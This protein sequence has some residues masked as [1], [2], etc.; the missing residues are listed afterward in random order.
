MAYDI[1]NL[2]QK[3]YIGADNSFGQHVFEFDV[4]KWLARWP[5]ATFAV[6]INR[7]YESRQQAYPVGGAERTGNILRWTV[8]AA[9]TQKIGDGFAEI[10]AVVGSTVFAKSTRMVVS[11]SESV[12]DDGTEP[13][14]PYEGYVARIEAAAQ[15]A[16]KAAETLTIDTTLSH[17]GQVADAK[18]TGDAIAAVRAVLA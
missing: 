12:C 6:F 16:I 7:P 1:E 18:A 11:I 15:A 3:I 2:P 17:A 8:G 5:T 14:E 13:P 4:S 9:D 10:H